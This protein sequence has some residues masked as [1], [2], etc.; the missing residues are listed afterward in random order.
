[1]DERFT[2]WIAEELDDRRIRD[3]YRRRT[4]LGV[5]D[6]THVQIDGRRFINFCSNN[7]LGLTHH[8]K[9]IEAGVAAMRA[10]G[11]GSGAAGLI[12]GYTSV[13]DAAE[14]A[15]A[16]WKGDGKCDVRSDGNGA[17]NE[18]AGAIS[19]VLLPSGYQANVAAVQ[20]YAALAD[21]ATNRTS[22]A[23][24]ESQSADS[25]GEGAS[26]G[27]MRSSRSAVRFLLDKLVHASLIDAVRG[28]RAPFRVFPHNN[29]AKLRRLLHEA[30]TGQVQVVVTES[31]FS[32]DGDAADLHGIC[33]LKKTFGFQLLLDEAHGTGVYGAE[34]RGVASELGLQSA[35]DV[36][37]LTLSKAMGG[38]GGAVCGSGL[39][40]EALLNLGRAYIYST[41]VSPATAAMAGAAIEIMRQEPQRQTR[42]RDLAREVRRELIKRAWEIPAGDSPIIPII[43]GS[44]QAALAASARLRD[45]GLL[46][47]AVRPPTVS[48]GASRLRVTLSSEHTDEEVASLLR[49]IG[50]P[51][52]VGR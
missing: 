23:E 40:L 19:A 26:S 6:E 3:R 17:A 22:R 39:F 33:E 24:Y 14:E 37:I 2:R 45:A 42:V 27:E 5:I 7:Y 25:D 15:I 49:A 8:P 46:V 38:S 52:D 32:M 12:S 4:A 30:P 21:A 20:T 47:L 1:V 35:V 51:T 48:P 13:H 29:M 41:S 16:R 44:E 11:A 31:I 18:H 50:L 36:S 28:T 9:L 34:G 43:L 10:A